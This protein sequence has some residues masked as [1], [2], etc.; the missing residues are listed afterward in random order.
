MQVEVDYKFIELVAYANPQT[1]K[2]AKTLQINNVGEYT[3][4]EMSSE[5]VDV[6]TYFFT[7][8]QVSMAERMRGMTKGFS[9][10]MLEYAGLT[11]AFRVEAVTTTTLL[12]NIC[13][14]MTSRH[15][16]TGRARRH[17]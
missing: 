15:I 13:P 2:V 12:R 16:E 7:I 10:C 4:C 6:S 14:C 11:E 8:F 9:L 17:C 3:S 1:G 5:S